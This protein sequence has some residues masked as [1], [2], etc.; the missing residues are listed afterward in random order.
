[1][2]KL[3]RALLFV[4]LVLVGSCVTKRMGTHQ[5]EM[6]V[7][8]PMISGTQ[9]VWPLYVLQ[10][11]ARD[12][13]VGS[14]FF[15]TVSCRDVCS[16][17]SLQLSQ[18]SAD[19]TWVAGRVIMKPDGDDAALLLLRPFPRKEMTQN[20]AASV[21][22]ERGITKFVLCSFEVSSQGELQPNSCR[23]SRAATASPPT[24]K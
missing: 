22:F 16:I 24:W 3:T 19:V 23:F 7:G 13:D 18:P 12:F 5:I 9:D 4:V 8:Y 1:M 10:S 15:A 14:S 11:G 17:Q 6:V 2:N 21:A 20:L